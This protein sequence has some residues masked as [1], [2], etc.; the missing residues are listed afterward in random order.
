MKSFHM[1]RCVKILKDTLLYAYAAVKCCSYRYQK[2]REGRGHGEQ[3]QA[4]QKKPAKQPFIYVLKAKPN[5][6]NKEQDIMK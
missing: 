6:A 2:I 5:Q 1:G 3:E 4:W